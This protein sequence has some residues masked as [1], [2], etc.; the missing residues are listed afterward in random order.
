MQ[1]GE[2]MATCINLIDSGLEPSLPPREQERLLFNHLGGRIELI[3]PFILKLI[4]AL[5]TSIETASRNYCSYGEP[6]LGPHAPV[7][8]FFSEVH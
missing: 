1:S 8:T 7:K 3:I 4:L 2:S 6:H 5:I